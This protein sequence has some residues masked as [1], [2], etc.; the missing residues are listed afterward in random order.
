[1]ILDPPVTESLLSGKSLPALKSASRYRGGFMKGRLSVFGIFSLL[2]A[3]CA[4]APTPPPAGAAPPVK[5]VI[6]TDPA[7]KD[8]VDT[9]A[10]TAKIEGALVKY[11]AGARAAT[12]AVRF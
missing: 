3:A 2:L 4:S 1:M 10:L 5:V 12:I 11:A 7:V 8:F 6:T 9:A